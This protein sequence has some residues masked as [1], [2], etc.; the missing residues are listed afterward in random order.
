MKE[1]TQRT[2]IAGKCLD[3]ME[4][5]F[6]L[7]R[8]GHGYSLLGY[9]NPIPFFGGTYI[10]PHPVVMV[11]IF[12]HYC[13]DKDPSQRMQLVLVLKLPIIYGESKSYAGDMERLQIPFIKVRRDN[14]VVHDFPNKLWIPSY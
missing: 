7:R 12:N 4:E 13:I 9:T 11:T 2:E 10:P 5:Y 1:G 3:E 6:L 14:S 8:Q